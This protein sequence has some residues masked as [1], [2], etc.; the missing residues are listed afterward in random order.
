MTH[1]TATACY[2]GYGGVLGSKKTH[3][4]ANTLR[5]VLHFSEAMTRANNFEPHTRE[6]PL[7]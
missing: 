1:S 7:H 3:V 2:L 5:E 4:G 6:A